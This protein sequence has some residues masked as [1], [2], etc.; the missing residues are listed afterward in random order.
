MMTFCMSM[1]DDEK[2]AVHAL[3]EA[4]GAFVREILGDLVSSTDCLYQH[5][6]LLEKEVKGA[7]IL[8][9]VHDEKQEGYSWARYGVMGDGHENDFIFYPEWFL[10]Q[11]HQRLRF[12]T[13]ACTSQFFLTFVDN[14]RVHELHRSRCRVFLSHWVWFKLTRRRTK[15]LA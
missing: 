8:Q 4:I 1:T 2:L 7:G 14:L 13:A 15:A 6:M 5:P 12:L 9:D 11:H 3:R 10:D